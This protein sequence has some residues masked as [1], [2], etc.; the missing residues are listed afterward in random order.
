VG[1]I[2]ST[3]ASTERQRQTNSQVLLV[4][5]SAL[6][7]GMNPDGGKG[8]ASAGVSNWPIGEKPLIPTQARS[9]QPSE[10]VL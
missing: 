2:P 4:E 10:G 9:W 1:L 5:K 8:L 3:P 7:L 6:S